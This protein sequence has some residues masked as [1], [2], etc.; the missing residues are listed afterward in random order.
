VAAAGLGGGLAL[1]PI[2]SGAAEAAALS[3]ATGPPSVP[4]RVCGNPADLDGPSSPPTGAVTVR[5]IQNLPEL[6]GKTKPGTTF[7]LSRGTYTFGSGSY[8]QVIPRSGDVFI[9]GPGAVINGQHE[10]YYAFTQTATHVTIEYLTIENFG[11]T[12]GNNN[13]GVVNH[14]SGTGWVIEHNTIEGNAGAGTMLG[15]GDV[16]SDNCL[17][18][19]G[20]YGFN[21]Y[22]GNGVTDVVLSDNEIS[23]ND[24]YNWQVKD[25]GCGCQGGGKFW[26]T[27]GATV[28]GNYVHNNG[29]VGIW[30]DTDNAGFNISGNYIA[31]NPA[32]GLI[33]EISYNARIADNTFLDNGWAKGQAQGLRF[34]TTAVYISESGSDPRVDTAYNTSFSIDDNAF[35]NNWGGVVL[36]E[37]ADRFCADGSDHV[38]TLVDPS[39]FTLASCATALSKPNP[40]PSDAAGCRWKTQNVRISHNTFQLNARAVPGCANGSG[41]GFNGIFSDYGSLPFPGTAVEAHITFDQDNHFSANTY[42]GP[43]SFMVQEKGT[44]I[45]WAKWRGGP[46]HQDKAST[47]RATCARKGPSAAFGPCVQVPK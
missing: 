35:V 30:V 16:V 5:P 14:D 19:N 37:N 43:W 46:F 34:P 32:E 26:E 13:Q 23:D 11:I 38:C 28:T 20:Q 1:V 10:N 4:N 29:S 45:D 12:G 7:W 27:T 36:W 39:E 25:P 24:T 33:Y 2:A 9:G 47:L 31:H 40:A 8:S 6:V 22:S 44:V 3:P 15:S 41:C 18:R 21:A 17:T 42:I